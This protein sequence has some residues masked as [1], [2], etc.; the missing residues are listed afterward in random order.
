MPKD[1]SKGRGPFA[2]K[3]VIFARVSSKDQEDGYSIDAQLHRLN[4]Y[5]DKRNLDIAKTFAVTESSTQGERKLFKDMLS[6][7]KKQRE[8]IALVTD[9][10]DRLQRSFKDYP[11]LDTMIRN[12]K[13]ELHFHVE[14][15]IIHKDSSSTERFIWSMG[16]VIAQNYTDQLSENVKRSVDQ[17]VRQGEWIAVAPLGYINVRDEK[18]KA[19]I[20]IDPER[21][22]LIKRLFTDYA[23]GIYTL[24]QMVDRAKT[25]GLKNRLGNQGYLP[26]ANIHRILRNPFYHGLMKVRGELHPHAYDPIIDKAIFDQCQRVLDGW[27]KKPFQYRGL[28]FLFRGLITCATS[29]RTVTSDRKRKTYKNGTQAEWIYLRCA[30]P[31]KPEKKM[32]VREEKIIGQVDSALNALCIPESLREKIINYIRLKDKSEQT[33]VQDMLKSLQTKQT[34][35]TGQL[36]RLLNLLMDETISKDDYSQKRST[37]IDEMASIQERMQSIKKS[38]C[39]SDR[40]MSDLIM[41]TTQCVW[42]FEG[43]TMDQKR[44]ILNLLFANLTMKGDKLLFSFNEPFNFLANS[45]KN[46]R[47]CAQEHA[48][49]TNFKTGQASSTLEKWCAKVDALRTCGLSRA[50]LERLVERLRAI[51]NAR[52]DE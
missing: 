43:S 19:W 11:T 49:R 42:S 45:T 28:D 31:D 27:H 1:I 36:E 44:Q 26:K 52:Q 5:C 7:I 15:Q 9:K 47:W 51:V 4:A 16:V 24:S 6:Y 37:L 32:W 46:R 38:S 41:T 23:S 13:L 40:S 39:R 25:M 35:L 8:P 18:G 17:K 30:N 29:G 50:E 20:T 21:A 14:N 10:I 3:A 34:R 48:V 2:R 33:S 12:G 22:P